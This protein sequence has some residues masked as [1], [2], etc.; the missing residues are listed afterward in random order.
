[1]GRA[2]PQSL[3]IRSLSP[4]AGAQ[5]SLILSIDAWQAQIR[6]NNQGRNVVDPLDYANGLAMNLLPDHRPGPAPIT[7]CGVRYQGVRLPSAN[8]L[9]R[10][11]RGN[12]DCQKQL[13]GGS[14]LG[15]SPSPGE[16]L[17]RPRVAG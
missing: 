5:P 14:D 6:A 10:H 15:A 11:V 12:P 1:M 4:V 7:D 16:G 3:T 9:D 17:V 8:A 2:Y 13:V